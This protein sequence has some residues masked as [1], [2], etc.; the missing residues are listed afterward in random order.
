MS[1]RARHLSLYILV[2]AAGIAAAFAVSATGGAGAAAQLAGTVTVVD[3]A[4]EGDGGDNVA[5]IAT[6]GTVTFSYPE[7]GNAHNVAFVSSQPTSCTQTAGTNNGP[8]PP[9]PAF[10]QGP[11]WAGTCSFNNP[12][13]Y[14]FVCQAHAFMTGQVVVEPPTT[15]TTPTATTPT[16]TMPTTPTTP[17]TTTTT[18]SPPPTTPTTP[19]GTT[20]GATTPAPGGA[21]STPPRPRVTVARR[22]EGTVLRGSVTTS[23][24]GSR[25]VVTALVSNRALQK[26]RPRRARKIQVGS[27]SKRTTRAG[28][29]SFA[30]KLNAAARRALARRE[31][32]SVDLRIV[33]TPPGGR[34]VT[35]TVTVALRSD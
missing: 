23:A 15:T 12:G 14:T 5:T 20:T 3:F 10:P 16:G 34:A 9:L 35:T 28:K 24:V 27:Q 19:G 6:G 17:T 30:V 18:T 2:M 32:L 21:P 8:V 4:F 25:I 29:T 22:Q 13:T 26:S 11:G 7:G 33:V 1:R 31:R